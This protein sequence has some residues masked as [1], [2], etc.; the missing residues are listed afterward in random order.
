MNSSKKWS[1]VVF[2]ALASLGAGCA[3]EETTPPAT[4]DNSRQPVPAIA[5]TTT[6][7]GPVATGGIGISQSLLRACEV[8]FDDADQAPKFS[9]DQSALEGQDRSALEQV[10]TC[11]TTGPLK[12]RN[13]HLIG[14]ADPRGDVEYNM[15]L[16]EQRASSV[17]QYLAQLGVDSAK[18][19]QTSRGK[20][21]AI[22]TDDA[23]WQRDRR[24]DVDLR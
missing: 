6:T 10:A 16:G 7:G 12:G 18:I 24:V 11:V 23:T 8:R 19:T 3:H 2:A 1:V 5:V 13:L 14:R 15:A 9:F 20:L 4:L 22:G 21:D 17:S